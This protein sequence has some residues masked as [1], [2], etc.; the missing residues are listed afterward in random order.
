MVNIHSFCQLAAQD[1]NIFQTFRSHQ[2]YQEIVE[3][4]CS[5]EYGIFFSQEIIE[6]YPHLLYYCKTICLEDKIGGPTSFY[7]PQIGTISP[8]VLRYIKIVGD[9]QREFGDL[10]NFNI[11]EIGGGFGGQCKIIHNICGFA[12]YTIIDLPECTPLI[13]K[14][15]SYF[16]IKN[17]NTINNHELLEQKKYDLIISNYALSEIDRFEQSHYL[18]MIIN[19]ADHGYII[20]NDFSGINPFSLQEFVTLLQN[21]RKKVKI[22]EEDPATIGNIIIW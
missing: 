4:C 5:Y 9:L 13:N 1:D 7:Y 18:E 8:T 11:V 20:Y 6:K 12:N 16:S 15:L 19:L 22:I 10:S 17:F 21:K 3:T 14:Y 2:I